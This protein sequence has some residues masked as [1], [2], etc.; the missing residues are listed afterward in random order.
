MVWSQLS[1]TMTSAIYRLRFGFFQ[2]AGPDLN[3][4]VV[5]HGVRPINGPSKHRDDEP[6]L[7]VGND[8]DEA[9]HYASNSVITV[10][11]GD[12]VTDPC[13]NRVTNPSGETI[14]MS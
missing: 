3:D 10:T 13:N 8:L 1:L 14:R 6:R 11:S 9:P 2:D 7:R 12:T 5:F 4:V